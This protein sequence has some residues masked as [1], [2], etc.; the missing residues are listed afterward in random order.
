MLC[1]CQSTNSF[2]YYQIQNNNFL[3]AKG[4]YHI[5]QQNMALEHD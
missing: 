5:H 4:N 1:K 2:W 3:S